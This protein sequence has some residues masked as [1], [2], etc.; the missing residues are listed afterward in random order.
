MTDA[1][2]PITEKLEATVTR[3][4]RL[5]ARRDA[6]KILGLLTGAAPGEAG[7]GESDQDLG[8]DAVDATDQANER[9]AA[10]V[11]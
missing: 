7:G 2:K 9:D 11:A 10:S 8:D 3:A 1:I 5:R 6:W 4:E